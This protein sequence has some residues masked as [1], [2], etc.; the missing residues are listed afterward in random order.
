M[1]VSSPPQLQIQ[2]SL[3]EAKIWLFIA[4]ALLALWHGVLNH[5]LGSTDFVT[6]AFFWLVALFLLWK[7]RDKLIVSP[8]PLAS[9]IGFLILGWLLYRGFAVFWFE[10]D[11]V[12]LLPIP[13][14]F[15]LALLMSGWEGLKPYLR[16]FF[17]LVIFSLLGSLIEIFFKSRP[18]GLD[19][20]QLT[21]EASTFLLHYLGFDVMREGVYIYLSNGSVEVL[22]FCTGGPLI[23][24]LFQLTL[25]LMLVVPLNWNLLFKLLLGI[26]GLGF[27]LGMVRVAL[28]AVVV[29]DKTAFDYWHGSE[30]NQ[31]FSLIAFTA[32]IV[33]AHFIY[34]HYENN[35]VTA[36]S[37]NTEATA[38]N[39]E[40]LEQNPTEETNPSTT[41]D[42]THVSLYSPRSWL[43]P[44]ASV[45]IAATTL[46]TLMIPQVGRKDIPPLSFPSQLSLSGWNEKSSV[47]LVK[48]PKTGTTPRLH[49]LQSGQEY[50]YENQA[51]EVTV[52]LRFFAPTF[53]EIENYIKRT[54]DEPIQSA[55]EEGETN[56][57]PNYGQ[58]RLFEDGTE[59]YL[60]ACLTPEGESTVS[61]TDYVNK[62][63]AGI[64]Q[65]RGLI[66]RLLGERSLRER[67]CLWVNLS[68]PLNGNT[69]A[70]SYQV[71]E[72]VFQQGYSQWQGLF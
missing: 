3:K 69:P 54:Y 53:G 14:L 63:N 56:Y 20:A 46:A 49:R 11:L 58:Y 50:T 23:A 24:L 61:V 47:S 33:A 57:L 60:S 68:T 65:V 4:T 8:K 28:L 18:G 9:V 30:G 7:Q 12:Q 71:L 13:G 45:T 48:Q 15:A 40:D 25:V 16:P 2:A 21:A 37:A 51:Q 27:F 39:A 43:L 42:I 26:V 29:S 38:D 44:I 31:I 70:N 72:A 55:Y 67:R 34:E 1:A 19:F 66:P 64:F 36:A 10:R 59:A 52:A 5:R 32:W 41:E 35:Y 22:Y 62:T 6:T 17:A